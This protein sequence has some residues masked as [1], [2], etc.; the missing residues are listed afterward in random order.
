MIDVAHPNFNCD[1]AHFGNIPSL[2]RR[3]K[4]ICLKNY[5]KMSR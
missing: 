2:S 1:V 5:G 4:S 3:R